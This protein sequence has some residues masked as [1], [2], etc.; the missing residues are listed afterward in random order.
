MSRPKTAEEIK[1]DQERLLPEIL[2]KVQQLTDVIIYPYAEGRTKKKA[3]KLREIIARNLQGLLDSYHGTTTGYTLAELAA[4]NGNADFKKA[5][6]DELS[7]SVRLGFFNAL[8][9]QS[10][11]SLTS[12]QGSED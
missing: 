5:F 3:R 12:N 9:I 4:G 11:E 2:E 7:N 6:I 8:P 1:A 10:T